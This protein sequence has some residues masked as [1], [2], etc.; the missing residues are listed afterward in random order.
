[1]KQDGQIFLK[2]PAE[3]EK[4][5]SLGG[6]LAEIVKNLYELAEEGKT[7]QDL[8][9]RA[10]ELC[11]MYDVNPSCKGYMGYPAATCIGINNQSVHNIP[12]SEILK[13]GDILTIDMVIDQ[14]GWFVDHAVTKLI[15]NVD[16]KGKELVR[17][18]KNAMENAIA[19]VKVGNTIGDLGA[20]MEGTVKPLGFSVLRNYVGHGIG[21]G[22]HEDPRIPCYGKNGTG[23]MLKEGMVFTIEPMV[24]EFGPEIVISDD[25]WSTNLKNGG[26]FAMFEHTVALTPSGVEI[27]TKKE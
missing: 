22:I 3:I 25:G 9:Q 12:S 18:T 15:G 4:M 19:E 27:L 24:A 6:I 23:T 5:K 8:E 11:K 13:S 1:M 26:R 14:N 16:A 20:A 21:R 17:N 10:I 2:T 7:P